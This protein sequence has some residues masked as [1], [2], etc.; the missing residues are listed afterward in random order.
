[1]PRDIFVKLGQAGDWSPAEILRGV[2][3]VH[4]HPQHITGPL[5]PTGCAAR[6]TNRASRDAGTSRFLNRL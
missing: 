5:A 6:S 4:D 1:M 2:A 3:A